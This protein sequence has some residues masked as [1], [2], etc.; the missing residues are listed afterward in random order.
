[1][2]TFLLVLILIVL[3]VGLYIHY[4]TWPKNSPIVI[5]EPIFNQVPQLLNKEIFVTFP[6]GNCT[7]QIVVDDHLM[8]GDIHVVECEN[9]KTSWSIYNPSLIIKQTKDLP[10]N[11]KTAVAQQMSQLNA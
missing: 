11:L 5:Q 9:C 10:D 2:D 3:L 7:E 1:M 4:L 6:C 8:P